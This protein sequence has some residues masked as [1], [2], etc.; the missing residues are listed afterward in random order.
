MSMFWLISALKLILFKIKIM[1]WNSIFRVSDF[2][3]YFLARC[4]KNYAIIKILLYLLSITVE[5]KKLP[6]IDQHLMRCKIERKSKHSE[7][8]FWLLDGITIKIKIAL[9]V[10]LNA[11]DLLRH[12]LC[13]YHFH[14]Q[15]SIESGTWFTEAIYYLLSTRRPEVNG[16]AIK[17]ISTTHTPCFYV[18]IFLQLPRSLQ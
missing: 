9:F 5:I 2:F 17:S 7:K 1:K 18:M 12:H 16:S 14:A 13:P 11:F 3:Y 15:W 6:Q 10:A 4:L 8:R